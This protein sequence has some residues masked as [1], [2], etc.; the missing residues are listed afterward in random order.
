MSETVSIDFL[1]QL[2]DV[3]RQ[4]MATPDTASYTAK[5]AAA[6]VDRV[7]QKF[8]EEAL[9]VALASVA[10]VRADAL[11]NEIADL[12]YHLLVLMAVRELT[13][14][15]IVAVLAERHDARQSAAE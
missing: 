1:L 13:L 3:I 12:V 8:G 5:L 2:E 15:D 11:Q 4:R 14:N 6:G 10:P 9:E 7:A